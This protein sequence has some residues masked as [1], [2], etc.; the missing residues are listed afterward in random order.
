MKSGGWAPFGECELNFSEVSTAPSFIQSL[1][2]PPPPPNHPPTP[3]FPLG[4]IS[5]DPTSWPAD[6]A[7]VM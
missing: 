1:N 3:Q 2:N 4:V 6:M 7:A 5:N